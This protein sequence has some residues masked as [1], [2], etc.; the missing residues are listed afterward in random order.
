MPSKDEKTQETFT[1]GQNVWKDTQISRD[2]LKGSRAAIPF[3]KEE[4]EI[5]QNIIRYASISV[6]SILD[7]GCGDGILGCALW[8]KYPNAVVTFLDI[9]EIMLEATKKNIQKLKI[10]NALSHSH[11]YIHDMQNA[12]WVDDL[13]QFA[14]FD[15]IISGFAIHH[16]THRRKKE[17][18]GDIYDLLSNNGFFLNLE[19]VESASS[20]GVVLNNENYIENLYIYHKLSNPDISREEV[21]EKYYYRPLKQSNILAPVE[22]QTQWLRELGYIDVDIFFKIYEIAIFGGRKRFS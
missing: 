2:Y 20:L 7:I 13:K 1:N 17:I 3:A 6:N 18:Y 8:E 12:N 11:F 22:L 4:I 21:A 5:I 14:P 16:L 19:R 9:S 10:K 15:I